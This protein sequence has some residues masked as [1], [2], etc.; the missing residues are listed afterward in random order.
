M[1]SPE[2]DDVLFGDSDDL[3]FTLGVMEGEIILPREMALKVLE[4]KQ[5][6]NQQRVIVTPDATLNN[7]YRQK[8][9]CKLNFLSL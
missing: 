6:G 3:T 9:K 4:V 1:E 8:H 5:E 2:F 7:I